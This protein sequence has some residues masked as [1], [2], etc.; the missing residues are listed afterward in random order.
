MKETCKVCGE[1]KERHEI[2]LLREYQWDKK[3]KQSDRKTIICKDC[4]GDLLQKFV[5]NVK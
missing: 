2:I 3:G 4:G 1:E 5:K